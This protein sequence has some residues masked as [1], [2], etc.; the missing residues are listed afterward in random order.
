MKE[1]CNQPARN[2]PAD[3]GPQVTAQT[4]VV[5]LALPWPIQ[6]YSIPY[7]LEECSDVHISGV[8]TR[9]AFSLSPETK[10]T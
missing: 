6:A 10:Y 8:F 5:H 1:N 9:R 4:R 2:F 3:T 7:C